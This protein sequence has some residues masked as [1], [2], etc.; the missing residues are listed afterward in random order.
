[1]DMAAG[2][3]FLCIGVAKA[4]TGWMYDQLAA[5]SDF[6]MPPIKEI[7]YLHLQKPN[8][9]RA[10]RRLQKIQQTPSKPEQSLT[11]TTILDTRF[12]EE[13]LK[14]VRKEMD[15][16][17]LEQLSLLHGKPRDVKGYGQI[18]RSKGN[19]LTG[20]ITPKYCMM[21]SG[22]F[23]KV[24]EQYPKVKIVL[25]LRDPVARFWSHLAMFHR[26]GLLEEGDLLQ[27]S[28]FRKTLK[29]PVI[30][31]TIER[32][33]PARIARRWQKLAP[34][35]NLHIIFFDDIVI[36]PDKTII[37][38]IQFLGADPSKQVDLPPSFNRKAKLSKLAMPDSI[39]EILVNQLENELRD[40]RDY[41]GGHARAWASKYGI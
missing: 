11:K 25:F 2:P 23:A 22:I 19:F 1:M 21:D 8:C 13:N 26:K 10:A 14:S 7:R 3:D 6:W 31:E 30:L 41:L 12:G 4:G 38:L 39:K 15:R 9:S 5:R 29:R 33:L 17:F 40:A 20:D 37:E 32:G 34:S 24:I 35:E 36:D 18:F 27:P 28:N 16:D